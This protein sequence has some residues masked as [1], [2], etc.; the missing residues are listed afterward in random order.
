[1]LRQLTPRELECVWLLTDLQPAGPSVHDPCRDWQ[2]EPAAA[3]LDPCQDWGI[4]PVQPSPC[5]LVPDPRPPGVL[6]LSVGEE[7]R[8]CGV[9]VQEE[10]I[11]NRREREPQLVGHRTAGGRRLIDQ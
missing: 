10:C 2:A 1:M 3:R 11:A 8:D 6:G 5:D 9:G 7:R 4:Q